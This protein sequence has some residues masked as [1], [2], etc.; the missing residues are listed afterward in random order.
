MYFIII[1]EDKPNSL[2]LRLE[3]RAEHLDYIQADGV[4]CQAGPILHD[5][6]PCG[7]LLIIK[8]ADLTAAE[9]FARRDPYAKAGLFAKVDIRPWMPAI[10]PIGRD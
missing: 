6:K 7:S 4:L 9:E 3:S 10:G 2:D 1:A 8:V 5:D